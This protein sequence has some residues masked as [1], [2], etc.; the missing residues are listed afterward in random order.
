M[1]Y[2]SELMQVFSLSTSSLLDGPPFHALSLVLSDSCYV[3]NDFCAFSTT[4]V[5]HIDERYLLF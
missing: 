1:R 5:N 3:L 2:P 4:S